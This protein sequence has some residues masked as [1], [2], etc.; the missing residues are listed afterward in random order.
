MLVP[1]APGYYDPVIAC[2]ASVVLGLVLFPLLG[3][4]GKP[5][6]SIDREYNHYRDV[7]SVEVKC[8]RNEMQRYKACLSIGVG[9]NGSEITRENSP[10]EV[11]QARLHL[12]SLVPPSRLERCVDYS[13]HYDTGAYPLAMH[14]NSSVHYL[15]STGATMQV[16]VASIGDETKEVSCDNAGAVSVGESPLPTHLVGETEVHISF[17]WL[18]WCEIAPLSRAKTIYIKACE[19]TFP[20][21][22]GNVAN[23]RRFAAMFPLPA[24]YECV[25]D[26]LV[27]LCPYPE[28]TNREGRLRVARNALEFFARMLDLVSAS[29]CAVAAHEMEHLL[30]RYADVLIKSKFINERVTETERLR[31]DAQLRS[32]YPD[33][34]AKLDGKAVRDPQKAASCED[35]PAFAPVLQR[36]SELME[37]KER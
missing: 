4:A 33:V 37:F 32:E 13:L 10:R 19:E 25:G 1:A 2:C 27:H 16:C 17:E 9:I 36:L 5:E 31:G 34:Y 30:D 18:N 8:N 29:D 11:Y 22:P 21:K 35:H 24:G 3:L 23:V 6:T 20:L 14:R 7:V 12:L 28:C 26:Q 15:S